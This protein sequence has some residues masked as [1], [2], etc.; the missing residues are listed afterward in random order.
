[1]FNYYI[2]LSERILKRAKLEED[3]TSLR[4]ELYYIRVSSLEGKINTDELKKFFWVNIYNA[5]LLIMTQE[6]IQNEKIF[7]IKR[8]KF[9]CYLLSLNDIEYGI[10]RLHKYKIGSFKIY[11]L[12]YPNF[13]KKLAVEKLDSTLIVHL[14]KSILTN[15]SI[16]IK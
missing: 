4:K 16:I 9:S 12:F 1:M 2:D 8:I 14:N 6:Q 11:N 13:I 7:K 3:T 15:L 10:L 5:Y